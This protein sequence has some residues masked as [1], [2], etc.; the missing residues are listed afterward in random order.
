MTSR[1]PEPSS[2]LEAE[3]V[4]DRGDSLAAQEATGDAQEG[5]AAPLDRPQGVEEWGT[6]A[7]EEAAG[8]PLDLRLS[9]EEPEVL[10]RVD[11]P[12]DGLTAEE[13]AMHVVPES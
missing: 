12:A 3:A 1:I 5:L 10:D 9:R 11:A 7:S 8:E 2:D 4:P 13:S 6:T